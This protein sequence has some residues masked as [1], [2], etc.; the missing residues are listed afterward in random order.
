MI[1]K[2]NIAQHAQIVSEFQSPYVLRVTFNK[3]DVG[4][5]C[6]IGPVYLPVESSKHKDNNMFDQITNDIFTLKNNNNNISICIIGNLNCEIDEIANELFDLNFN[7]DTTLISKNRLNKDTFVN[8]NGQLL[9]EFC[10]VNNMKILNGRTGIDREVGNFTYNST[11]SNNTIDYCLVS[12]MFL[13]HIHGFEMDILDQNLSDF[14][15][16]IIV[17]LKTNHNITI[18]NY[19]DMAQESNIDYEPINS[20]CEDEKK[21]HQSKFELVKI[22]EISKLLNNIDASS[23]NKRYI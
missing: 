16:P 2:N 13:S 11:I 18:A 21:T 5:P 3:E 15:S 4:F 20:K 23:T 22:E 7:A 19:S 12:Q 1:V 6:I 9:L 10:K 8:I 14:H 17:T